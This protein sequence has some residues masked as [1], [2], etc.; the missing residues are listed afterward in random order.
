M[1]SLP[2]SWPAV[3]VAPYKIA[4]GKSWQ[5]KIIAGKMVSPTLGYRYKV[6]ASV[7]LQKQAATVVPSLVLAKHMG[8]REAKYNAKLKMDSKLQV[9]VKGK[10]SFC[11]G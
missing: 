9:A 8:G 11:K 5:Q 1:S 4:I 10:P 7:S 6:A 2:V 3:L